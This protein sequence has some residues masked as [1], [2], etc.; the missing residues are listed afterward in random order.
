LTQVPPQLICE[1]GH[2]IAHVPAPQT[3]PAGQ[4]LPS[5]APVQVPEAP[6]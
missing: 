5:L 2:E 4:A 6:Q 1:P 3:C